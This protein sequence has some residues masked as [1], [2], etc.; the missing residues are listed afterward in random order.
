MSPMGNSRVS[1]LVPP[2]AGPDPQV[3]VC[4]P[5]SDCVESLSRSA[6]PRTLITD[7][8]FVEELLRD[9]YLPRDGPPKWG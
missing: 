1:A 7:D 2:G 3:L 8:M 6:A 5:D 4:E 9:A